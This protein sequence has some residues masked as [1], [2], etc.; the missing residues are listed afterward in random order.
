[1]TS[2][3]VAGE[4]IVETPADALWTFLEVDMDFCVLDET[5]V[6]KADGFDSLLSLVPRI[7]ATSYSVRRTLRELV[8]GSPELAASRVAFTVTTHWGTVRQPIEGLPVAAVREVDGRR[9]GWEIRERLEEQ[10]RAVHPE[11]LLMALAQLRRLGI[12]E[13]AVQ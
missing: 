1:N 8:D 13:L 4:P 2:F 12:V 9:S 10:G 6:T 5:L 11:A 7:R 3:N